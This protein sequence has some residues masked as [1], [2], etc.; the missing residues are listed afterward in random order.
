MTAQPGPTGMEVSGA[1]AIKGITKFKFDSD[2]LLRNEE[3]KRKLIA[4]KKKGDVDPNL[5]DFLL[6]VNA[7]RMGTKKTEKKETKESGPPLPKSGTEIPGTGE[8]L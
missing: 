1:R 8:T 3:I 7:A 2:D 6:N 4:L 5:I